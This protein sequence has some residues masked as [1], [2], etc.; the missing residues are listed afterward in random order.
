MFEKELADLRARVAEAEEAMRQ[1]REAQAE[2][3]RMGEGAL[4]FSPRLRLTKREAVLLTALLRN[5]LMMRVDIFRLLQH[6]SDKHEIGEEAV[7]ILVHR[8]RRRLQNVGVSIVN[9][10]GRGYFITDEDRKTLR[11]LE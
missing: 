4:Y 5:R 10:F 11:E 9:E 7:T 8:L 1:M 2:L 3:N 6:T